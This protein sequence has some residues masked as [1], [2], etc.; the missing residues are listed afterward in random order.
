VVS[1]VRC[2]CVCHVLTF[3][4]VV[5]RSFHGP[6]PCGDDT[7][8]S[9]GELSLPCFLGEHRDCS[10]LAD[11]EGVLC[12]ELDVFDGTEA[13]R[14]AARLRRPRPIEELR[15]HGPARPLPPPDFFDDIPF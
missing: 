7:C 13:R 15:F 14:E 2:R 1:G 12:H 8:R 4:H 3:E 10:C 5:S 9:A 6:C 11:N